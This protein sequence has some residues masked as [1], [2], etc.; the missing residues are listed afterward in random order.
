MFSD[1]TITLH[2][3][4]WIFVA[5]HISGFMFGALFGI[6]YKKGKP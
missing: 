4:N 3:E 1:I 5:Y 2:P 6:L